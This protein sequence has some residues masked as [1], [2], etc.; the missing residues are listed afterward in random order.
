MKKTDLGVVGVMYAV[1]ILFFVM[2]Q[3]IK[4]EARA[5]PTFVIVLLFA[6]TTLYVIQ[7]AIAAKRSGVTSGVKEVFADFIPKQFFVVLAMVIGYLVAM[8]FI[9]FYI[10]TVAFIVLCLLFLHVPKWQIA[11]TT[12][13]IIGL[14]YGAFTLFLGVKLPL[15]LLFK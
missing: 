3:Q 4:M 12:V 6:L 7:M 15:G 9:G 14:V 1:C 5:Y 2:T 13:F 11:L 8:Y 10:S